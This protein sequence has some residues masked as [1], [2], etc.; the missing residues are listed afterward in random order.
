MPSLKYKIL[1]Q[2]NPEL[3]SYDNQCKLDLL[4]HGGSNVLENASMFIPQLLTEKPKT[5]KNKLQYANYNNYV[6]KTINDLVSTTFS[7][8]ISVLQASDSKDQNSPGE[9]PKDEFYTLFNKDADLQG[10]SFECVLRHQ[11][12]K[13]MHHLTGQSWLGI[14]FTD[15]NKEVMTELQFKQS[16]KRAY[17]Y[18]IQWETVRDYAKDKFGNYLFFITENLDNSRKSIDD[19][20][21]KYSIIFNVWTLNQS[22]NAVLSV[23]S[24]TYKQQQQPDDNDEFPLVS[25]T[26][27]SFR[28]IPIVEYRLPP[29]INIGELLFSPQITHYRLKTSLT[30]ALAR[31]A[32]PILFGTV[33]GPLDTAADPNRGIS[34]RSSAESNGI[35]V[36]D[37]GDTLEFVEPSGSTLDILKNEI[38]EI[39]NNIASL[40]Y[41]MAQSTGKGTTNAAQSASSKQQDNNAKALV[42]AHLGMCARE[43]A[44]KVFYIISEAKGD[45]TIWKVHGMSDYRIVDQQEVISTAM[46]LNVNPVLDFSPTL[47][48]EAFTDLAIDMVPDMSPETLAQIKEEI[49]NNVGQLPTDLHLRALED[50]S[51]NNDNSNKQK[52]KP[53]NK[54]G[55]AK[56][57]KA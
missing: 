46:H 35:S 6:A 29:T 27:T 38:K 16:G 33:K 36:G 56:Q 14:D 50:D 28:R 11:Q 24:R 13:S 32:Q 17:V 21:S 9:P 52:D 45:N 54:P 10:N 49:S 15:E 47:K 39:E 40:T 43:F 18:N 7:K 23:Y 8:T 2:L 26:P 31:N 22:N 19:D 42:C 30:F 5:Y 4:F 53:S 44:K 51:E 55:K 57:K 1:K 20:G 25:E 3:P 34:V 41:Q 48:I 37:I 12:Q